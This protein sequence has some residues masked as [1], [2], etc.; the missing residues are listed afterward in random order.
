MIGTIASE[1]VSMEIEERIDGEWGEILGDA[2]GDLVNDI[3]TKEKN[4]SKDL[5]VL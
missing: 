5:N 2:A 3:I 1:A 4:Q